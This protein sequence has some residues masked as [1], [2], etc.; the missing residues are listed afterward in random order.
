MVIDMLRLPGV[1]APR[2]LSETQL[3]LAE[4]GRNMRIAWT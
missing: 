2:G 1:Q 3:G 4:G